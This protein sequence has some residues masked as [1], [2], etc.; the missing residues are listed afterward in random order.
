[1]K[2][3]KV[4][5]LAAI[6]AG[7]FSLTSCLD[8]GGNQ[9]TI[10][11]I[12]AIV[13]YSSS[14]KTLIYPVGY[15]Y[16]SIP[17][18]ISSIANDPTYS[19]GDC[20]VANVQIDY[21]S[22]DN[23]NV[24]TN[25]FYVATGIA[26]SPFAKYNLNF[27]SLDSTALDNELLLSDCGAG[28]LMSNNYKRIIAV[29]AFAS[30]LTDQKNSYVITMD[31]DQ[32]PETVDGTERVYTLCVRAQKKEEG[33]APTMSNA[34]DPIAIEG[35]QFYSMLKSKESAAGK[36]SVNY[37]VKYPLT[38]NSDSTKIAT[39]GYSEISQFSIEETTN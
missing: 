1:M 12:Y 33:K 18:Y 4:L 21:D 10:P 15:P 30:V 3:L 14:M 27:S 19:S 32:E 22:P 17:L 31:Y 29:P 24:S 25:G 23:A 5:E 9:Q 34:I 37:R 39:W 36:K 2:K 8:G 13:D 38:F 6:A 16:T 11:G 28:L 7:M 26:S 35:G 20:I